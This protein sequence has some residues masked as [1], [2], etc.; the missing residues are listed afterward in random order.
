MQSYLDMLSYKRPH[1]SA[2]E[3]KFINRF[4]RPL[5]PREDGSGNLIIEVPQADGTRSTVLWSSHTDSVHKESGKQLVHVADDGFVR[6]VGSDCLGA[7][8]ASGVWLMVEMIK[9]KV[10]GVYVFH[11]GEERGGI[12]SRYI[13]KETPELL[14]GI[15]YAIAFD[16]Q[17]FNE[18]IT[19]Q[20]GGRCCSDDFARSLGAQISERYEPS[21]NGVFTDT[22]HYTDLV[23]ECTNISVGYQYQHTLRER[24]HL[25][26]LEAL[27]DRLISLDVSKLVVARDPKA[28][29]EYD[30]PDND[31]GSPWNNYGSYGYGRWEDGLHNFSDY[32][33][34][35]QTA[36]RRLLEAIADHPDTVASLLEEY[37][38]TAD[39]II[40]MSRGGKG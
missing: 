28:I 4:L 17:D 27:R 18:V 7:D 40:D 31:D 26:H 19:H 3:R 21:S 15:Q 10:P 12:G 29:E 5:R 22:A 9:A 33:P 34:S 8:C 37:G 35:K 39:N 11:R 38:Y 14:D 24:Q 20:W 30:Y 23:P 32:R 25:G 16:R 36:Y 1:G 2:S 13:A 6:A